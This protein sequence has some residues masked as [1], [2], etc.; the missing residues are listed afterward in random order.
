MNI[1]NDLVVLNYLK[2]NNFVENLKNDLINYYVEHSCATREDV[3]AYLSANF[4]VGAML[5]ML[6]KIDNIAPKS[7]VIPKQSSKTSGNW[8]GFHPVP[9]FEEKVKG[10]TPS[11][12]NA[13]VVNTDQ[14]RLVDCKYE[15]THLY[16]KTVSYKSFKETDKFK[17][18]GFEFTKECPDL[19]GN[20]VVAFYLIGKN[21][22]EVIDLM[23]VT[24]GGKLS[25]LKEGNTDKYLR[26]AYMQN[27]SLAGGFRVSFC[28]VNNHNKG[29]IAIRDKRTGKI[30][31]SIVEAAKSFGISS[32]QMSARLKKND[33]EAEYVK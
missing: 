5:E 14:N 18:G 9:S 24:L 28:K 25:S 8:N 2:Q 29:K 6:S 10:E 27:T 7:T 26:H 11:V 16:G 23:F 12:L 20:D 4:T 31:P 13:E 19:S 17:Y 1:K 30:Y 22:N 21:R 3:E 32:N 33:I 15:A